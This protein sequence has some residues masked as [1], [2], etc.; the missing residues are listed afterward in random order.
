MLQNQ[1]KQDKQAKRKVINR[2]DQLSQKQNRHRLFW[3][4]LILGLSVVFA[5][6][7]GVRQHHLKQQHAQLVSQTQQTQS[8]LKSL[9]QAQN[10]IEYAVGPSGHIDTAYEQTR[11]LAQQVGTLMTTFN[12]A[13]QYYAH[14]RELR[15]YVMDENFFNNVMGSDID[16]TNHSFLQATGVKSQTQQVSCYQY[17]G[18]YLLVVEYYLY[19]KP[20]D[21][22]E[23]QALT[24][25]YFAFQFD[26]DGHT[27][28]NIK[29]V[30]QLGMTQAP[31]ANS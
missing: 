25:S 21:L 22:L 9:I 6:S 12:S 5:V 2:W 14:R 19:K 24:P 7:M 1:V 3:W 18:H 23:K 11:K 8:Q 27:M 20:S 17:Q 10:K 28:K 13:Q 30:P 31:G 16:M 4:W 15:Q 29:V 26:S